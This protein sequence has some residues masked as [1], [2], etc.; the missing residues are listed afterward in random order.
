MKSY[1]ELNVWQHAYQFVKKI[2]IVTRQ[3]PREELYVFTSQLRRSSL[4]IPSNIAE[5]YCRKTR[6]E[7]VQFLYI[8]FGSAHEVE[9]QLRLAKDLGYLS[10]FTMEENTQLFEDIQTIQKM[11]YGMINK[12]SE[13]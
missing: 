5:G 10:Q 9:T 11:I 6:K 12:L 2:Y 8:A 4:S 13:K 3:F 7:Y 1:H